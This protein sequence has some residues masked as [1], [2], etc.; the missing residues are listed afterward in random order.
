VLLSPAPSPA[1]YAASRSAGPA[2]DPQALLTL[3]SCDLGYDGHR[4]LCGVDVA[5]CRGE[6][7]AV[8]GANGAGKTTLL[9][10]VLGAAQVLAGALEVHTPRLGYVPQRDSVTPVVPPSSSRPSVRVAGPAATWPSPSS[11]TAASPAASS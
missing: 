8:T 1:P 4:L 5:I 11:S 3:H 10:A 9:R 2:D 6:C 7:V